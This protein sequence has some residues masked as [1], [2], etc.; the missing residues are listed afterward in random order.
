MSNREHPLYTT[1]KG[2][3]QRCN[4]PNYKQFKNYGGRGIYVCERWNNFE[5]FAID[6]GPRPDGYTLDRIDNDGPY[7]PNNCRWASRVTQANNRA[8]YPR[9]G[10]NHPRTKFTAQDI[11][12]IRALLAVGNLKQTQIAKR[13]GVSPSTINAINTGRNWNVNV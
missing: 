4:D 9:K 11:A 12:E 13:F 3:R 10:V 2:M 7:S 6:M 8:Q 5:L 1:W